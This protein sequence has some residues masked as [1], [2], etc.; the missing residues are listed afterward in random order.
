MNDRENTAAPVGWRTAV[1]FLSTGSRRHDVV[2]GLQQELALSTD[3]AEAAVAFA[4]R[5]LRDGGAA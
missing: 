3:D 2:Q 1:A 4:E 5:W